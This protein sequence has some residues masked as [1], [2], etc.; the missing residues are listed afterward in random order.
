MLAMTY[1]CL[2]KYIHTRTRARTH[3][4]TYT[5]ATYY[6]NL[7]VCVC[8]CV[9][10]AKV[11]K[12]DMLGMFTRIPFVPPKLF[13]KLANSLIDWIARHLECALLEAYWSKQAEIMNPE[14]V[15]ILNVANNLIT[16]GTTE[17]VEGNEDAVIAIVNDND[18]EN[19]TEH[20]ARKDDHPP[21]DGAPNTENHE[22]GHSHKS[23]HHHHRHPHHNHNHHHHSPTP[24]S[25]SEVDCVDCENP[26]LDCIEHHYNP[27]IYGQKGQLA[28]HRHIRQHIRDALFRRM[29]DELAPL[30]PFGV[31]QWVV[32]CFLDS[33]EEEI[34]RLEEIF[35]HASLRYASK[36]S[37]SD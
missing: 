2:Y 9:L 28:A 5:H 12:E 16:V 14:E 22:E 35:T 27:N 4:Y 15:E 23:H 3:T 10:S 18:D 24:D 19:V 30:P 26:N 13:D 21:G 17:K 29:R 33:E 11:F 32:D 1:Y 6:T 31:V 34:N 25:E 37:K 36:G 20:R 7:C 8:A